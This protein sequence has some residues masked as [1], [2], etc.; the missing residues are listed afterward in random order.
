MTKNKEKKIKKAFE[1]Q[2]EELKILEDGNQRK[3]IVNLVI[4]HVALL[5]IK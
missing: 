5:S 3:A 1:I 4:E 2:N